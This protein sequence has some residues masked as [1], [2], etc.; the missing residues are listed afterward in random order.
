MEKLLT[1]NLAPLLCVRNLYRRMLQCDVAS[2]DTALV[3]WQ[4]KS[5]LPTL[6]HST[7]AALPAQR[8]PSSHRIAGSRA[9]T[10]AMCGDESK[11]W[12]HP[13]CW[14]LHSK[15]GLMKKAL[16]TL[17]RWMLL[18]LGEGVV[19]FFRQVLPVSILSCL[20]LFVTVGCPLLWHVSVLIYC[21]SWKCCLKF[22]FTPAC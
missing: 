19:N 21:T 9:K 20:W 22:V 18:K 11:L 8:L 13:I 1:D 2:P 7:A 16:I 10:S 12:Y 15:L 6:H 4:L 14:C 3:H 5:S 17:S